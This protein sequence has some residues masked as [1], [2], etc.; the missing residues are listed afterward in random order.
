[1]FRRL[2][3]CATFVVASSAFANAQFSIGIGF[4]TRSYSPG[5]VYVPRYASPSTIYYRPRVVYRTAYRQRP[6]VVRGG[7]NRRH[8]AQVTRRHHVSRNAQR[9][10][11]MRVARAGTRR[12][13]MRRPV[14]TMA[15]PRF[16]PAAAPRFVPYVPRYVPQA[17]PRFAGP[18]TG[19]GQNSFRVP[20]VAQTAPAPRIAG[21]STGG[22]Q[23]AF[24]CV[25]PRCPR[26]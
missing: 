20:P 3:L 25:G 4:G 7:P 23:A 21:P 22:G 24:Y 5:Y 2:A 12:V 15:A 18:S 10:R 26:R 14:I 6:R 11:A 13:V 1:M 19:F 17:V 9:G 8:I 16:V